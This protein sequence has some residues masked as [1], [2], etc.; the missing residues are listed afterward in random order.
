MQTKGKLLILTGALGD[1]HNKAAQ[2]IVEAAR[3]HR[4]EM[5]VKV[6]DFLE[7]THPY[8]HVVGKYCFMQWVKSLPSVY[9]FLYR[10]TRDDNTLSGWFKRMR[11]FSADRMVELLKEVQPTEVVSTFPGAAAAMSYLKMKGLADVTTATVITDFTDHSYWIHPLTD[12]YIVGAEHVKQALLRHRVSG[13]RIVVTGIPIR[14]P[15]TQSYD[16]AALRE[17][18]GLNRLM[19]TVLVMGGG[20]GLIGKQ[21]ASILR[22]IRF[23]CPVQFIIV[24]GRNDKLRQRLEEELSTADMPH[25]V[26]ITGFVDYVHELM[27]LSD[28]I[29]TKPG[30]LTVSEAL[31]LELPMLLYK[32]IPGQEQDNARYLIRIG[33]AVEAHS[34]AE[35]TMQLQ[36]IIENRSV[37]FRM[38]QNAKSARCKEGAAQAL[39]AILEAKACGDMMWRVPAVAANA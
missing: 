10:K 18:F 38:K 14:L 32:P 2:A 7:W 9:G 33:A 29:V 24:C 6:V 4:P 15:F 1:G 12:R 22:E 36:D 28:L 13:D 20:H 37:L 23:P 26:M 39:T 21:F 19:P 31:A 34:A 17:K 27:A 16:R 30:G 11:T 35:L 8:M 5:E 3:H 25:R